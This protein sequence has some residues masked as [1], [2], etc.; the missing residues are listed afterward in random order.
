M[1]THAWTPLAR[2]PP[3]P[4][5]STDNADNN[6]IKPSNKTCPSLTI[7]D[8]HVVSIYQRN[9]NPSRAFLVLMTQS[10]KI[11]IFEMRFVAHLDFPRPHAPHFYVGLNIYILI[12][13]CTFWKL[14]M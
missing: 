4:I 14:N 7:F 5:Q 1:V 9:V 2:Q 6:Q 3:G 10:N 12:M 11:E 13:L 8:A